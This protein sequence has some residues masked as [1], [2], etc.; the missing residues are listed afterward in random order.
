M[1]I[2]LLWR[3]FIAMLIY[4]LCR[5]IFYYYNADLLQLSEE[6]SLSYILQSS[7]RFDLTAVLYIN[8]LVILLHL[9]PH[10][11]KYTAKYQSSTNWVYWIC[12]I[13]PFIFNLGD[14]VYYRFTGDRSS[15][16][17]FTE[18]QNENPL[19]FLRFFADYWQITLAGFTLILLWTLLYRIYRPQTECQI[20]DKPFYA[21]STLTLIVSAVLVVG[22][23]RG[24]LGPG[25]RP[26]GLNHA[27]LY[28][29]KPIQRALVLNTPFAM[30]R[31]YGKG[32]L[33]EYQVM[34]R[35]QALALYNPLKKPQ[36]TDH[37][38][39][40]AFK[41]RNVII[42]VW[43]SLAREWVGGL[44]KDIKGYN[45]FTPFLDSLLGQSYYFESA[46]A[47][48]GKSIDAMPAIFASIAKPIVPFVSSVYSGNSTKSIAHIADKYGY[49]TRF[50][51]NAPNGSMGFDAMAHQ[52]GFR[53]YAGMT[54]YNNDEDFD[55]S[56]G[57]WDEPF[58]QFIA[59]DLD[60]LKEPFL[61]AEFTTSSHHPFKIPEKYEAKFPEGKHPQHRTMP[62]TDY[63]LSQF[64]ATAKTKP[65]YQNT[66]FVIVADHSIPGHLEEY[67]NANG[68]H[69]I[70]IIFF[71][72]QGKLRGENTTDV[73]QQ[74]DI[75]P[76]LNTLL[77]FKE[78]MVAFGGDLFNH[79]EPHFAINSLGETY[80]MVR[81]DY[82]LQY[83]PRE[84]KV[85][86][87]YNRRNDFSCKVDLKDKQPEVIAELLPLF[88]AYLQEYSYRMRENKLV[89]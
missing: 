3:L 20:P 12:N 65:W 70:P 7:L 38:L 13:P 30:I 66:L 72:P 71:D 69:L 36:E 33:P 89:P 27:M 86:A 39:V 50:Y 60:K 76:T 46:Y 75:A 34:P 49:T 58:F 55:G 43:E 74:T 51:H 48:G 79:K 6:Q 19:H 62:Y 2:I 59:H 1:F 84:D 73:A 18:F 61:A 82:I 32:A 31:L 67:Q 10:K 14:T 23:I 24:G 83:N 80:Q 9:L 17:V 64:F 78:E 26:I 88:K 57:I 25:V 15:L 63:A 44:N 21:V 52:L 4:S 11:V 40:G 41:G 53:S 45:G 35:E 81:G 5:V 16:A 22:G 28:V 54:E 29:E 77:G 8:L 37:P 42:I 68:H 56:W 47:A 87:L 85:I